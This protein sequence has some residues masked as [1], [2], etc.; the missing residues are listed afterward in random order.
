[1]KNNLILIVAFL[2]GFLLFDFFFLWS[3]EGI[4]NSL[5]HFVF[6]SLISLLYYRLYIL[7][8]II[9]LA[10]IFWVVGRYIKKNLTNYILI[11]IFI[12]FLVYSIM[13]NNYF[14]IITSISIP[15]LIKLGLNSKSNNKALK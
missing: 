1:M 2:I 10:N 4:I 6:T 14:F 3:N 12:F 9:V 11:S 5:K 13:S 7:I 8:I 15:L